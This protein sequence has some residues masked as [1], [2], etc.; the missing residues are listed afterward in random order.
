MSRTEMGTLK[1][2]GKGLPKPTPARFA[3]AENLK[4]LMAQYR[5]PDS[6][7]KGIG[8]R[9][10]ARHAPE[11]SY[12]TIDR[13]LN[14]YH[15]TA[16]NLDS[17]DSVSHFFKVDTFELLVRRPMLQGSESRPTESQSVA[18]EIPKLKKRYGR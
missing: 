3:I 2:M 9:E 8:S 1:G 6:G 4:R 7:V 18:V 14:P 13:M 12:K 15:P 11:I 17:L 10:L 16:P 5:D